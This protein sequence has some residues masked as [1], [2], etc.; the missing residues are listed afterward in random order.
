MWATE[1][2]HLDY[3]PHRTVNSEFL[4]SPCHDILFYTVP[5]ATVF[6]WIEDKLQSLI[7]LY[8]SWDS[9]F[10][11]EGKSSEA[12]VKKISCNWGILDESVLQN[13]APSFSCQ[14]ENVFQHDDSP[15]VLKTM[16]LT[17]FLDSLIPLEQPMQKFTIAFFY[18]SPRQK[19]HGIRIPQGFFP[20]WQS[21]CLLA[22]AGVSG[23]SVSLAS[24]S[25]KVVI[26]RIFPP[27]HR[28]LI[29]R[30][31][32]ERRSSLA[33][34]S[35][36]LQNSLELE[37]DFTLQSWLKISSQCQR[38]NLEGE[39]KGKWKSSESQVLTQYFQKR[40]LHSCVYIWVEL[41]ICHIFR[42]KNPGFPSL[43]PVNLGVCCLKF[44]FP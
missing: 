8:L 18:R 15:V 4:S 14:Q 3:W 1:V 20:S 23:G 30:P 33:C 9:L 25:I 17:C 35:P 40:L 27:P 24:V 41:K 2:H 43:P 5:E 44:R 16:F 22:T 36:L 19:S 38:E 12:A 39:G 32:M 11:A 10:N 34:P 13:V 28:T 42:K 26:V 21:L 37:I 31:F 6:K 7:V 29:V